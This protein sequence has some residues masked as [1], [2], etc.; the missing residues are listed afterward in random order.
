MHI[1]CSILHS[2]QKATKKL[3]RS[4]LSSNSTNVTAGAQET[5][6]EQTVS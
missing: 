3:E 2:L 1:E 5:R 4:K 6:E